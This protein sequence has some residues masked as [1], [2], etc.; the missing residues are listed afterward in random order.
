MTN[1]AKDFSV[2]NFYGHYWR[3]SSAFHAG[4]SFCADTDRPIPHQQMKIYIPFQFC[5]IFFHYLQDGNRN[6]SRCRP[7]HFDNTERTQVGKSPFL[8]HRPA[9]SGAIYRTWG[10]AAFA[11]PIGV[12]MGQLPVFARSCASD[13]LS[14]ECSYSQDR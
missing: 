6:V 7:W 1:I 14:G 8:R 12:T 9:L 2:S 5:C 4:I 10:V 13:I 11:L 3:L